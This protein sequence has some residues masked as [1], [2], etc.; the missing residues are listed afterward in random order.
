[1]FRLDEQEAVINRYGFNSD[2]MAVVLDRL[3]ERFLRFMG[4]NVEYK[5]GIENRLLGINLG[6]NKW[7]SSD[8]HQDYVDGAKN[9]A[10]FADYLV[11][12]V[13]SP[14]TPRLRDLQQKDLLK[15]LISEVRFYSQ[16]LLEV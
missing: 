8:S 10:P 7:S 16:N 4:K 15:N 1:M 14:N 13:S 12:N 2:G 3:R 6:K 11:I 5:S 9:F